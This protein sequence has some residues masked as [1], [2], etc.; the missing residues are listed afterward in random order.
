[1]EFILKMRKFHDGAGDFTENE[2]ST[3]KYSRQAI[4]KS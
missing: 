1:M 2:D 3:V 4:P